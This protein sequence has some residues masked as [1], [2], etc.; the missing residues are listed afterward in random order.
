MNFYYQNNPNNE[1]H[2]FRLSKGT[3]LFRIWGAQGGYL[4]NSDSGLG[5]YSEGIFKAENDITL[6]Y[7]V[8]Q[9]GKCS[10][11]SIKNTKNFSGGNNFIGTQSLPSCTGGEAT[12]ICKDKYAENIL[13]I[14]G[15]GGGSGYWQYESY[16]VDKEF[17]GGFGGPFAGDS[18]GSAYDMP[19]EYAKKVRGKGAT[20]SRPGEGG[21]YLG[22]KGFG[23]ASGDHGEYLRGGGGKTT[24][25]ASAGGGGCGYY[26]GGGGADVSGG[27]GG[28]SF[29]SYE[30]YNVILLGGNKYFL[31]PNDELK[32]GNRGN[33]AIKIELSNPYTIERA[34]SK[35]INYSLI[36]RNNHKIS[37]YMLLHLSIQ[38]LSLGLF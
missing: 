37:F 33:G 6:Y 36:C 22:A 16:G 31:S 34:E 17:Y 10:S 8:G 7:F 15:A 20:F 5:A 23:K 35:I 29:A 25:G 38:F 13:L 14:S 11:T 24:A 32:K 21:I 4:K 27:G 26:G 19:D 1:L 18:D 9:Q 12:F 28:S 30:M 3:W 2:S